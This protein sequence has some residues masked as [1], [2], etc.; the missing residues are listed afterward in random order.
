MFRIIQKRKIWYSFSLVL[1]VAS[2]L[3]LIFWGLN[4]GIDFTGG[5]ILELK[6]TDRALSNDEISS[7]L[8]GLQL[9]YLNVQPTSNNGVILKTKTLTEQEHQDIIIKL[10]GAFDADAVKAAGEVEISPE[11][12]GLSGEGLENVKITTSAADAGLAGL[13]QAVVSKYFEELRFD[14]IGPTIGRELKSK[15]FYSIILVSLAIILYLAYTFRKISYPVESWKYGVSAVI[16]LIHDILIVTGIFSVLGHFLGY[17][18]DSLF[19]TALL[20]ILGF[21]VH[22]TIVTFDRIRENLKHHEDK[23]FEELINDSINQTIVRSINTSMTAI[24]VLITIYLFGGHTIRHFVLA[25]VLGVTFGTYSS[26][27]IA[28]PLLLFWYKLKKF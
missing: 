8:S 25:L 28:S 19:V 18:I 17:Q 9:P 2:L 27:F 24:Y 16:A 20:T 11:S 12:L 6:F 4:L 23:T 15:A 1:T 26:I 10:L 13:N 14:S 7:A 5:S 3:S 22:D 21:S